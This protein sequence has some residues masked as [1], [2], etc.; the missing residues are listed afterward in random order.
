MP[1]TSSRGPPSAAPWPGAITRQNVSKNVS[2]AKR[3]ISAGGLFEMNSRLFAGAVLAYVFNAFVSHVP[4]HPLRRFYLKLFLGM[5]GKGTS[6]QMGCRILHG[7]RIH[8]GERNVVNFGCMLD[9][10]RFSI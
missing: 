6:V 3:T 2:S 7:R 4:V 5:M 1:R 9:G 10:R 8:L